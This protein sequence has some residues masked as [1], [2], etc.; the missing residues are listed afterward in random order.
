[1]CVFVK[2]RR[3]TPPPSPLPAAALVQEQSGVLGDVIPFLALGVLAEKEEGI[4][5]HPRLL[6]VFPGSC[7]PE[8]QHP[9]HLLPSFFPCGGREEAIEILEA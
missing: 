3:K 4:T 6:L 7:D 2:T 9:Q 5:V 1:M 8:K